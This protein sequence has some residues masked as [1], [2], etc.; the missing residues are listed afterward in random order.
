MDGSGKDPPGELNATPEAQDCSVLEM[1]GEAATAEVEGSK[2]GVEI[3]G[4]T[5]WGVEKR[6]QLPGVVRWQISQQERPTVICKSRY[7]GIVQVT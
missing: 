4:D 7:H 5:T 1:D 2:G 3:S 6:G